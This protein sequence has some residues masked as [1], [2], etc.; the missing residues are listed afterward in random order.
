MLR[1]FFAYLLIPVIGLALLGVETRGSSSWVIKR[2]NLDLSL[3]HPVS[4]VITATQTPASASETYTPTDR[5]LPPVGGNTILVLGASV[6]V[7][8]IIAGVGFAS[9]GRLKH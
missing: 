3:P 8:I 5:V 9:R 1:R 2:S 6:L 7:L 4:Q